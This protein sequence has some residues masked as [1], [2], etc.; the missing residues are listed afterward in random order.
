[1]L[2]LYVHCFYVQDEIVL[3]QLKAWHACSGR[4]CEIPLKHAK[5]PV[6][7]KR[8]KSENWLH[9]VVRKRVAEGMHP[10]SRPPRAYR[11]RRDLLMGLRNQA[12][13]YAL[14]AVFSFGAPSSV[15][16]SVPGR[17][18]CIQKSSPALIT[19][20]NRTIDTPRLCCPR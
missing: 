2:D 12:W 18:P 9:Q 14:I 13:H 6:A 5:V 7:F 17:D 4:S 15:P 3:H 10:T 19:P 11:G 16:W 1:M 20:N 8:Q